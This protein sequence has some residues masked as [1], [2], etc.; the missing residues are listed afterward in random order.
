MLLDR[1]N[2]RLNVTEMLGEDYLVARRTKVFGDRKL[3]TRATLDIAGA[4]GAML[5]IL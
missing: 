4:L 2:G 5:S 3:I 1:W